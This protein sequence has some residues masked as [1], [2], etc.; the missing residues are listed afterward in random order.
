MKYFGCEWFP[1]DKRRHFFENFTRA[2]PLVL[3]RLASRTPPRRDVPQS[4]NQLSAQL[5]QRAPELVGRHEW[6]FARP[7]RAIG[8]LGERRRRLGPL[9]RLLGRFEATRKLHSDLGD[10][11]GHVAPVIEHPRASGFAGCTEHRENVPDERHGR[12][13]RRAPRRTRPAH[14]RR[15]ESSE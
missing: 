6:R 13:C 2:R 8:V 7:P 11:L 12:R 14:R 15:A 4:R 5:V 3:L 1:E 9:E 10:H